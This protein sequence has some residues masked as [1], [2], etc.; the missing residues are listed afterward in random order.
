MEP[1]AGIALARP[2]VGPRR[3]A[4]DQ[5][6]SWKQAT[7]PPDHANCDGYYLVDADRLREA[8]RKRAIASLQRLRA[9]GKLKLGG[10]FEYLRSDENWQAFVKNLESIDWVAY[11]QPPPKQTSRG[12]HVV[13]YLTRYLTGG[14]ISGGRIVKADH[15]NVTFLAREGKRIGGERKQVPMTLGIAAFVKR[16]CLHIQPEQLTKTRY[17][18][19]WSN[20]GQ[21]KYMSRCRE[22]LE[23]CGTRRSKPVGR[24]TR[25]RV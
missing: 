7:A 1:E 6:R 3:R 24:A 8:Y 14:P 9:S 11:I 18:G 16:W 23:S 25:R 19:G 13:N 4:G 22:L 20:N 10:K 21:S 2:C 17:F 12:D 5:Q 15:R